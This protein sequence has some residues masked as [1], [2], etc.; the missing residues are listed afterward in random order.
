[1]KKFLSIAFFIIA[2]CRITYGSSDI[3]M[4]V[5]GIFPADGIVVFDTDGS[6]KAE[7]ETVISSGKGWERIFLKQYSAL[8]RIDIN[9]EFN[10]DDVKADGAG[11]ICLG[12]HVGA[13][14]YGWSFMYYPG[15]QELKLEFHTKTKNRILRHKKIALQAPYKFSLKVEGD[16]WLFAA[17]G[18]NI[19]TSGQGGVAVLFRSG[20]C[21]FNAKMKISRLEI[22]GGDRWRPVVAFGDSITHHCRWQNYVAGQSGIGITNG[23]MACDDTIKAMRRFNS[24]VLALKP[25]VLILYIGTNNRDGLKAATDVTTMIDQARKHGIKV[26]VCTAIPR[27][28]LQRIDILNAELR[29]NPGQV[30][31]VDWNALLDNGYKQ[32]RQEYGGKVHPNTV[33]SKKMA[34]F[35]CS[36]KQVS[37]LFRSIK[38][39]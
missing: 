36:D 12:Y 28:K 8:K 22:S 1:M 21:S 19:W 35:F 33:G 3:I 14:A 26:I 39:N 32:I 30:I 38:N 37:E 5:K 9:V 34:D 23:G 24:D 2:V 11:G 10:L 18:R 16:K 6:W 13:P 7:K 20:A 29:K 25:K 17:N 27:E 4:P 15:E 31:L